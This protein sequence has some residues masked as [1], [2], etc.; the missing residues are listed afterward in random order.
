[1]PPF[2][3]S[4]NNQAWL[5]TVDLSS[6]TISPPFLVIP[7]RILFSAPYKNHS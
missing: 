2:L 7:K 5:F 6:L 3:L 1:M 4:A